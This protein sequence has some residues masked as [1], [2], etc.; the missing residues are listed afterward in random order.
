MPVARRPHRRRAA[1][2]F[3]A[4]AAVLTPLPGHAATAAARGPSHAPRAE[5]RVALYGD[6]IGDEIAGP[7]R[8]LLG[9][10]GA[11]ELVFD[12][13]TFGGTN[14]CDWFAEARRDA[15]SF[16]PDVVV[17]VFIGNDFTACMHP[18][19]RTL[20]DPEAARL[21][22][23]DTD[24]LA[25]IFPDVPV[26]RVGMARSRADQA[27][28]DAG[29]VSKP[30]LVSTL[31]A[32]TATG[33]LGFVDGAAVLSRNGR[34]A[35][36]LACATFDQGCLAG[37]VRVRAPDGVHLC[38]VAPA[39]HDGVL[40]ACTVYSAGATRLAMAVARAVSRAVTHAVDGA[41]G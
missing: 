7:L 5:L 36:T 22:A 10:D 41:S 4:L 16:R 34:Y 15:R 8:F 39:A 20:T 25:A 13:N 14:A 30:D 32:R 9:G 33:H 12:R 23:D 2:G 6:S 3:A 38:P 21:T 24:E 37:R 11:R 17:T 1:L 27:R 31:L 18:D 28:L 35:D 19:G 29:G 40:P 26:L